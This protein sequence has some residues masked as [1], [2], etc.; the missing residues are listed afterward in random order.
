MASRKPG[1]DAVTVAPTERDFSFLI[2][3]TL[4]VIQLSSE[5]GLKCELYPKLGYLSNVTHP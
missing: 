5:R 2:R 1:D 4:M 3:V